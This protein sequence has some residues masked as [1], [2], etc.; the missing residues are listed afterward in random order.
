MFTSKTKI[1]LGLLCLA[2]AVAL[3]DRETFGVLSTHA[4]GAIVPGNGPQTAGTL[5]DTLKDAM[6][7]IAGINTFLHVLLLLLLKFASYFLQADFF[8]DPAMMSALYSIWQLSRDI[9]NIIFALMLIG[10]SFYVIITA[11]SDLIKEKMQQFVLAV[12]LVN[13]SW[14]FPR[15]ILDVANVL[16]ATVYSIPNSL[17]S[18]DC[19]SIG[20]AGTTVPCQVVVDV[21][22][23]PDNA[24]EA[25][26]RADNAGATISCIKTL[27][28]HATRDYNT[29]LGTM[30]ASH[31]M[32]NGI[33]VS[34][35]RLTELNK[36][37]TTIAG[38]GPLAVGQAVQV[39]I[40]IAVNILM[41][42]FVQIALV[43]PLLG[44][45]LGLLIRIIVIWVTTAFMP[46]SFLGYVINGKLGTNVFG[47]ETNIW[48]EFVNAA[49]LP[50]KVGIPIVIGFIM[51]N[52]VARISL[53]NPG[54]LPIN[55]TVPLLSG[56]NDWWAL[57][58]LFAAVG[59]IWKG[60]FDALAKSKITGQF[61]EKIRAFGQTV[62]GGVA[63]LPLLTPI[64]LP[65]LPNA[66]LGTLVNGPRLAADA[67][68]LSA[69]GAS[70]ESFGDTLKRRFGAR[71][72]AGGPN[73][74]NPGNLSA[75]EF[76][77]QIDSGNRNADKIIQALERLKTA[78]A[79]GDEDGRKDAVR[80]I[81]NETGVNGG[82][83]SLQRLND[84]ISRSSN[85]QLQL[86]Q[87]QNV[88]RDAIS[89]EKA[90]PTNP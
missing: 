74:N 56:V 60:S 43:L 63:Q 51:L 1:L 81:M 28:C 70:T 36:I 66:N 2:V 87:G 25:Q 82:E 21:L 10:V 47:F 40:Q 19:L 50:A 29:A 46:F 67:I 33:A 42:F 24:S 89:K 49:L 27:E 26:F 69:S 12:I 76:A 35:A 68:R 37:P 62:A 54:G 13:M 23:F 79:A 77:K 11:K 4:Q 83:Q 15:V 32:L 52:S 61:T 20:P 88:L 7:K 44:L 55:F 48:D 90:S 84:I 39:S 22:I 14:F 9:M 18:P 73:A 3:V 65:G 34:F 59:I 71:G 5:G 30:K 8:N 16:T 64:P 85:Q 75:E 58:W 38:T 86:L 80:V 6:I 78:M 57:I 72:P 53:P 45:T 41:A 31:A 17:P